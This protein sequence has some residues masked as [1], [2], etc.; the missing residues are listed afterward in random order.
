M[1]TKEALENAQLDGFTESITPITVNTM[2]MVV[3]TQNLQF[4]FINSLTDATVV[5]PSL[6]INESEQLVCPRGVIKHYTLFGPESVKPN[7]SIEY[8]ARWTIQGDDGG[9]Y[10]LLDL[11][12]EDKPYYVYLIV[13]TTNFNKYTDDYVTEHITDCLLYTSPSPRDS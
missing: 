3:G 13:P 9:D 12:E 6:Y 11:E 4:D 7:T 5:P 10:A 8:Y 2:Q 1:Q